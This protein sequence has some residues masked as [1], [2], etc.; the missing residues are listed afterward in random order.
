MRTLKYLTLSLI[1]LF[2]LFQKTA[3]AQDTKKL[4]SA[5][6]A[7]DSIAVLQYQVIALDAR[8]LICEKAHVDSVLVNRKRIAKSNW[9][10]YWRGVRDGALAGAMAGFVIFR[11]K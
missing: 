4:S 7:S 6:S 9:Q 5:D 11:I 1:V 8:L 3:W 10:R 2:S